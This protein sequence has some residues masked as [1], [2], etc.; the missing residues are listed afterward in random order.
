MGTHIEQ[1]AS[2][3]TSKGLSTA[4]LKQKSD[5]S[6]VEDAILQAERKDFTMEGKERTG[7]ASSEV[8][9]IEEKTM[10]NGRSGFPQAD[11]IISA[12]KLTDNLRRCDNTDALRYVAESIADDTANDYQQSN[13]DERDSSRSPVQKHE[14]VKLKTMWTVPIHRPRVDP[15][16]FEDPISEV[17][18]TDVW[19]ASAAYNVRHSLVPCL[20]IVSMLACLQDGDISQGL[21]C[22]TR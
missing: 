14:T 7:F 5:E 18:W 20:M 9:T 22:Y 8:P 13:I 2:R 12:H 4:G 1:D 10:A 6:V 16:E 17:F 15:Y 19:V 3:I 21:P 11:S